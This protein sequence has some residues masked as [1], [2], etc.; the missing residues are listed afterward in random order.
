MLTTGQLAQ[1]LGVAPS[2]VR[3]WHRAGIIT[4]TFITAGGHLRWDEDEVRE[5]L[6]KARER[7]DR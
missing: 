4:P 1:R 6:R 5:Q 7:D 3:N 2:T